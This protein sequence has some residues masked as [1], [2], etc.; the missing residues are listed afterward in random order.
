MKNSEKTDVGGVSIQL[1]RPSVVEINVYEEQTISVE[2]GI[3][4]LETLDKLTAGQ[5]YCTIINTSNI[6]AP[7]KEFF[8]FIVSQRTTEKN[9]VLARAI[10]TTNPAARIETQNFI[11]SFKPLIETRLF[12]KIDEAISWLEEKLSRV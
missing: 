8:K 7:S 12:S 10:V 4:I 2:K 1:V 11:N 9:N 6:Y 3:K 5:L